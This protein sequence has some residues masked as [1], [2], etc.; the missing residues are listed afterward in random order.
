[1]DYVEFLKTKKLNVQRNP[2]PITKPIH[3]NLFPFQKEVVEMLLSVGR[4]AAFLDTGLGKTIIQCEWARH[5]DGKVLIIAPLAVA[6]QTVDEAKRLLDL[7]IY[8]SKDGE[9][10]DHRIVITNYE[11]LHLFDYSQFRGVVLDESSI[12]KS[13]MGKTKQNL[14][15]WFSKTEYK[16]CCTATPA[17]NDHMELG[18]HSE[19]LGIMPS[20]EMLSRWF[21]NDPSHVG[22]YRIKGHA[23]QSFWEWVASWAACVSKPSDLGYQDDRYNLPPLNIKTHKIET[24]TKTAFDEGL[25]FDMPEVNATSLH[26]KRRESL[27]DRCDFV[28]GL[29]NSNDR[30]WIVWC[31]SNDESEMLARMIPDAVEVRGSNTIEQKE[32]RLMAFT[33]GE[34]RVIVSKASICG[35]GM[36]WAH[37]ND[38]AF[39]SISYSYEQFYQAVRRSWRFGQKKPVN[40]H[41]VIADAEVQVWRTIERKSTDHDTMKDHMK[42]AIFSNA[43]ESEVK[44][45]YNPQTQ[46]SLPAWMR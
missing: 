15:E 6:N 41:V 20:T 18:N 7:D 9:I 39:A 33:R 29:V 43:K 42:H 17:P 26:R 5:I 40:V 45:D 34:A 13:F 24:E 32:D 31:E 10:H 46:G 21:I 8:H 25:L 11:R 23:V 44:V 37:C 22:A 3:K 2:I 30:P 38:I 35:F 1:M 27:E 19:F 28:A 36:N 12:L 14:C 4:G 16:L